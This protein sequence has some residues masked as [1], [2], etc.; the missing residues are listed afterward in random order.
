MKVVPSKYESG[1][2]EPRTPPMSEHEG[3]KRKTGRMEKLNVGGTR[4][5][6]SRLNWADKTK[7][8]WKEEASQTWSTNDIDIRL[9][10]PVNV[11]APSHRDVQS[12]SLR[13]RH[14]VSGEGKG[15]PTWSW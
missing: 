4:K 5:M 8:N 11:A 3:F 6:K 10:L 9:N 15:G 12:H 2:I 14:P 13:Q 7:R 1:S